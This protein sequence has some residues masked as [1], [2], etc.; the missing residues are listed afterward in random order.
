MSRGRQS[1]W[2]AV[3][4]LILL[5]AVLAAGPCL[6]AGKVMEGNKGSEGEEVNVK[7]LLVRGQYTLVDFWS[8][9][10]GPCLQIAPILEKL[11]DKRG[12]LVIVK[13]N[14]NRPDFKGIDWK[15]PLAQQYNIR[16]VPY[17]AIFDPDGKL[18]AKGPEAMQMLAQW[19]K[20]AGM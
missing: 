19:A 10:C 9:Y 6:A 16:S 14:I 4:A 15:S 5:G 18:L 11:A 2:L 13:L 17:M 8:P 3:A 12:N 7:K 1:S 20:E